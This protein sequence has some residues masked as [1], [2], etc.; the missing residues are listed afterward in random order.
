MLQGVYTTP[1]FFDL[2]S[3]Q[4]TGFFHF[5]QSEHIRQDICQRFYRSVQITG[6]KS[7]TI[8]IDIVGIRGSCFVFKNRNIHTHDILFAGFQID[9]LLGSHQGSV[10]SL[11]RHSGFC[12]DKIGVGTS[13]TSLYFFTQLHVLAHQIQEL[14][15]QLVPLILQKLMATDCS[16]QLLFLLRK[17]H[18]GRIHLC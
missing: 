14:S 11:L 2:R 18:T 10:Q 13:D 4:L 7:K 9:F 6:G 15:H 5:C 1:C 8:G 3:H 16:H 17:L 12:N